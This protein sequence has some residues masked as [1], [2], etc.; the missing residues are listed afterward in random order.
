MK[1]TWLKNRT[2]IAAAVAGLLWG[3]APSLGLAQDDEPG[4]LNVRVIEVKPDKAAEWEQL[5]KQRS[6]AIK[7]AG[8]PGRDIWE[9]VRGDIDVYHIVTRVQ[10]LGENDEPQPDPLGEA[11]FQQWRSRTQQCVGDRQVLTLRRM[12]E[13]SIPAKEGRKRNLGILSLRTNGP[14]QRQSYIAYL[15]D[16]YIPALKKAKVN[17]VYVSRVFAGD[18]VRT[19]AFFTLVDNWAAFDKPNPLTQALGEAETRK[20][21]GKGMRMI[22]RSERIL[23]RYRADLSA[24]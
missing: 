12:P 6:E 3:L 18:S 8:R 17:G 5:Q 14:G 7:K 10:N 1:I 15:R 2:V 21:I 13:L 22:E 19:W 9:V 20:L 16:D 4:W 11:G 23:L 24:P